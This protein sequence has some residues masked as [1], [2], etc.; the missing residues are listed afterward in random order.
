VTSSGTTE[1]FRERFPLNACPGGSYSAVLAQEKVD[2]RKERKK[3]RKRK[4]DQ[5]EELRRY[6]VSELESGRSPDVIAGRLKTNP[7]P[8][9]EGKSISHES[10]YAW[11][12]D[13]EGRKLGLHHH[14][15]SGQPRWQKQRDRKKKKNHIPNRISI[16]ERP[17]EVLGRTEIGHWETDSVIFP[18][19][20]ER[21][22]VQFERRARYVISYCGRDG[23]SPS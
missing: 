15:L 12:Y 22:S 4:L 16:W 6:V 5:D 23:T 2:R 9:L 21:I 18:G 3:T 13:G 7:P 14:L 17:E 8:G 10:I 11:I 20:K 19:Q 1:W